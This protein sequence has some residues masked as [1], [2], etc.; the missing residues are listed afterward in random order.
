MNPVTGYH[1]IAPDDLPWRLSNLMRIPNAD[2]LERTGS[3]N[4]PSPTPARNHKYLQAL[5]Q[6]IRQHRIG[7]FHLELDEEIKHQQVPHSR[8]IL[9]AIQRGFGT[10]QRSEQG[11]F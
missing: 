3:E 8:C 10:L 2:F 7:L 5:Q 4:L 9:P 6:T 11:A 1:L